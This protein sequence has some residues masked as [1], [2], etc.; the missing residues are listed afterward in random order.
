MEFA[1]TDLAFLPR[2]NLEGLTDQ[3]SKQE[4][5]RSCKKKLLLASTDGK[6]RFLH[7]YAS[8]ALFQDSNPISDRTDAERPALLPSHRYK[9]HKTRWW[10][11]QGWPEG[12]V[13]VGS[14]ELDRIVP[15]NSSAIPGFCAAHCAGFARFDAPYLLSPKA[16]SEILAAG[17]IACAI[18]SIDHTIAET[19]TWALQKPPRPGQS[20][21]GVGYAKAFGIES[22]RRRNK[23][24]VDALQVLCPLGAMA[25]R[26]P[27]GFV[28]PYR[29]V[30]TRTVLRG[31]HEAAN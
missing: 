15:Q 22:A 31:G 14:P 17:G 6:G 19:V 8:T 3:A 25:I 20:G 16:P 4:I 13:S 9:S 26:T 5:L 12:H 30:L 21:P 10:C 11:Q 1:A 27:S 2:T 18:A 29:N 23:I 28:D 24:R 7:A